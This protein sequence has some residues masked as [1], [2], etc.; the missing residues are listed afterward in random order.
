MLSAGRSTFCCR[1]G[2]RGFC[3]H[4]YTFYTFFIQ[5]NLANVLPEVRNNKVITASIFSLQELSV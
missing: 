2:L 1:R 3:G 4:F 5:A